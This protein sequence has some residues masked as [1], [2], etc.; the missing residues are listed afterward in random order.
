MVKISKTTFR[1]ILP[2]FT[3]NRTCQRTY[4]MISLPFKCLLR[5]LW[6]PST[7]D[8]GKIKPTYQHFGLNSV[9]SIQKPLK[10]V[11]KRLFTLS[12]I[13]YTK[14]L[15][16]DTLLPHCKVPLTEIWTVWDH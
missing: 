4:S 8:T 13:L 9:C 15:F 11:S 7:S 10:R 6:V 2:H 14:T 12:D 3:L 1:V 5:F 16:R